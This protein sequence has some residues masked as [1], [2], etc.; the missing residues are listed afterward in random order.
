MN[1]LGIVRPYSHTPE[2][3]SEENKSKSNNLEAQAIKIESVIKNEYKKEQ[4]TSFIN[5]KDCKLKFC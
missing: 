1:F 5:E 2:N 4:P 3:A